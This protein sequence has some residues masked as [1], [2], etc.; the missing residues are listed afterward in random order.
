MVGVDPGHAQR[1]DGKLV[2]DLDLDH[3]AEPPPTEQPTGAAWDD[4]GHL[5][6]E[7]VE[8]RQVEVIPVDMRHEHRVDVAN[9]V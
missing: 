7:Q 9:R 5:A 6:T 1:A 4:H 2:A 8:R 3:V